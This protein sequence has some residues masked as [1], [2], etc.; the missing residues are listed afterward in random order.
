METAKSF[1][2]MN[3]LKGQIVTQLTLDDDFNVPDI[4]ADIEKYITK[5]ALVHIESVKASEGRVNIRGR[6]DFKILYGCSSDKKII[7]SMGNSIP[8]DEIINGDKIEIGRAH[9]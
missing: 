1:I 2:H 5:D 6:M 8:F 7:H 9:V 4:N 3:N